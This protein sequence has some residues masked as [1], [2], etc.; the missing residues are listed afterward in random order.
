MHGFKDIDPYDVDVK[1]LLDGIARE[2]EAKIEAEEIDSTVSITV[3]TTNRAKAQKVIAALPK[4]F[5]YRPGEETVWRARLLV[6]PPKDGTYS[7]V[8]VLQPKEGTTGRRAVAVTPKDQKPVDQAGLVATKAE[9]KKFLI[10]ILDETAGHLRHIPNG[11]RMRVHFGSLVLDEW[12]KD[13]TEYTF[14]E[15]ESHVSRAGTRGTAH[16]LST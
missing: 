5:L 2:H 11:M 6:N 1:T 4:V 9:Y 13:K 14:T 12:K 16:M 15:L 10:K 8:A 7:L 3:Q